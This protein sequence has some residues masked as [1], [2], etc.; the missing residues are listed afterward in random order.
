VRQLAAMIGLAAL[1]GCATTERISAAGDVHA[2]MIAIRD[3]DRATFDA[4]VDRRALEAQIQAKIVERTTAQGSSTTVKGLGIL[5]SGPLARAA[6]GVLI[7]PEV[8]RAVADYYGYRPSTPIPG[9]FAIS[10][11]LKPL[12]DGRVCAVTKRNGPC[13]VTFADEDGVWRLVSFD[14]DA[15]MLRLR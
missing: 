2:L 14:G 8:F 4:H 13:L 10:T 1:A 6:S 3:D 5:M 9:T 11:A 7:Q 15:A 12:P